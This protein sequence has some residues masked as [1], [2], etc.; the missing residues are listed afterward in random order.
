M[1]SL[2]AVFDGHAPPEGEH[3]SLDV[4]GH[5]SH[6]VNRKYRL[7]VDPDVVGVLEKR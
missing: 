7:A 6:L 4:L 1:E 2:E 5:V 3:G